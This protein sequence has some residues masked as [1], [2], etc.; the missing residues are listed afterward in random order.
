VLT[1][2]GWTVLIVAVALVVG[3]RLVGS[4]ELFVLGAVAGVL[5][6]GAV[7]YTGALRVS[8]NVDRELHPPRVHAG[9]QSRVDL[10][11]QNHGPRRSPV[12]GLLDD[13]SGTRGAQLA[14]GPLPPD[15]VARAAYRLPTEHR[16]VLQVG[17]LRVVM[18]D[19][20]G[21]T[22]LTMT[23]S[24]VSELTVYPRVDDITPVPLTTGADPLAGASHPTAIGRTGDDFYALRPYQ[25]GDDLRRV[26]WPA[27]ARHDELMVRQDELP[28][29]ARAT[30]LLDLRASTTS[31]A[32]VEAAVSAAASLVM[33]SA[34]RQDLIRLV[35]SDGNDSG[36]A[37]GHAHIEAI[38]E[39]LAAVDVSGDT[40]FTALLDR[41]ARTTTGG[42]LVALVA[43]PR[44]VD[45]DMVTGLRRRFSSVYV[46]RFDLDTDLV[47]AAPPASAAVPTMVVTPDRPFA[48]AWG[49]MVG[50][51]H[52]RAPGP[53]WQPAP[54]IEPDDDRWAAHARILS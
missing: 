42:A 7:V 3:G 37:A 52:P 36:F 1:R 14:V 54:P 10:R 50:A 5:V 51:H 34:R 26:H 28:W 35:V 22:R 21:F 17:P 25:V 31:A 19:P 43:R 20:F 2:Q 48:E 41:L 39:H 45:L 9:A 6:L 27:T 15:G 29:Q 12:L 4:L 44:A 11:V 40:S 13:V 23:A 16:G 8:V 46:V 33:A 24:D 47:A 18:S 32:S 30:V 49:S 38:L 53:R